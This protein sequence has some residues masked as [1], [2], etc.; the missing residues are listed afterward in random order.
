MCAQNKTTGDAP[1]KNGELEAAHAKSESFDAGSYGFF[2]GML[3]K[4]LLQT[5]PMI[6]TFHTS[7]N[8]VVYKPEDGS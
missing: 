8:A 2:G 5:A 4:R 6:M 1:P 7:I 3:R